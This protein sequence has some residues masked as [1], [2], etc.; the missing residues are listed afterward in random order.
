MII[1]YALILAA[2]QAATEFWPISSSAHLLFLHE[3]LDF[4]IVNDFTFDI[5]LH[6]GTLIALIMFFRHDLVRYFKSFISMFSGFNLAHD[7]QKTVFNIVLATLP[8]VVV[9]YFAADLIELYTRHLLIVAMTL[10]VGGFFL[11]GVERWSKRNRHYESLS[12]PE[13][14]IIGLAQVLAFVPGVSRSGATIIAGMWLKLKRAEAA[15]FSFLLSIP[16]VLGA[17]IS[18]LGKLDWSMISFEEKYIMFFAVLVAFIIGYLVIKYFL[19]F[20]EKRSLMIFA[21]Y[22]LAF[23]ALILLMLY[24]RP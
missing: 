17:T 1:F 24:Y 20:L 11:W 15:R 16:A 13:A 4:K 14:L 12:I 9:G 8:A 2:V 5:A 10:I 18:Q 19:K 6:F 23:G 21:I 3:I 22:R 7:D